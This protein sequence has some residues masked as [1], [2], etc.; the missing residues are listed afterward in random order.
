[1]LVNRYRP[2]FSTRSRYRR[3]LPRWRAYR[4]SPRP[5]SASRARPSTP[6]SARPENTRLGNPRLCRNRSPI[7]RKSSSHTSPR[8]PPATHRYLS[9]THL[10]A[11][12]SAFPP[13][14]RAPRT[15]SSIS[16]SRVRPSP[17]G[18]TSRNRNTT[19]PRSP[20]ARSSTVRTDIYT[21]PTRS[22][23]TSTTSPETYPWLRRRTRRR[24]RTTTARGTPRTRARS[25]VSETSPVRERTR[26]RENAIAPRPP[27]ASARTRS[28]P[29]SRAAGRNH[30]HRHRHH[31]H[32]RA[33][34]TPWT[35]RDARGRAR[36]GQR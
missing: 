13:L 32:H 24:L 31:H 22:V 23:E 35:A 29:A 20:P 5:T 8:S 10:F 26:R 27:R 2:K 1:M 25:S 18:Q 7:S 12:S 14:P 3:K 17:S 34:S 16:E 28:R 15:R 6:V 36:E 9:T 30:H 11:R 19:D 4:R 33:R 21:V